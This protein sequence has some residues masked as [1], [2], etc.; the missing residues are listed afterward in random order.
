MTVATIV[1]VASM[2]EKEAANNIEN[3]T[4]ASVIYN[5]LCRWELPYLNIDATIVYALGGKTD[6]LTNADLQIDSPYNTY[7]HMG[8]PAGPISNPGLASLNA[9][10][11]PDDTDFFYY[12]L[13][14][15]TNEHKF[16]KTERV[17]SNFHFCSWAF[18]PF[19]G[20]PNFALFDRKKKNIFILLLSVI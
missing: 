15:K 2:V 13:N 20:C 12:A 19:Q 16:S 6:P 1:N 10:L 3:Y 8:L 17:L 9:A 7:T 4:V 14:P 18:N 11:D 5:R